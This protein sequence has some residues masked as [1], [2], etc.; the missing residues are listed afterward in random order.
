MRW[1]IVTVWLFGGI[2]QLIINR[3]NIL[4]G[5][6]PGHQ[7][8]PLSLLRLYVIFCEDVFLIGNWFYNALERSLQ[9][10]WHILEIIDLSWVWLRLKSFAYILPLLFIWIVFAW[11]YFLNAGNTPY[12]HNILRGPSRPFL[13]ST[14]VNTSIRI[15]LHDCILLHLVNVVSFLP[16]DDAEGKHGP[17]LILWFDTYDAIEGFD[18]VFADNKSKPNALSVH[19]FSILELTKQLEQFQSIFLLDA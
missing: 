13:G 7:L 17:L 2:N 9:I 16:K 1:W 4:I 3:I 8:M 5:D 6:N 11:S 15:G 14:R 12:L 18:D 19:L 10:L